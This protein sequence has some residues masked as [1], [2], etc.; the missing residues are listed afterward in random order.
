MNQVQGTV[1]E[2]IEQVYKQNPGLQGAVEY[3]A[4]SIYKKTLTVWSYDRASNH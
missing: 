3:L 1:D 2:R 4:G